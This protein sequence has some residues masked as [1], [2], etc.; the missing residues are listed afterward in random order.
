MPAAARRRRV[1]PSAHRSSGAGT[2]PSRHG[3]FRRRA[4]SCVHAGPNEPRP[5]VLLEQHDRDVLVIRR[6]SS[7]ALRVLCRTTG[8]SGVRAAH[9]IPTGLSPSPIGR[10]EEAQHSDDLG[11]DEDGHADHAIGRRP[12]AAAAGGTDPRPR[13]ADR[14]K[15]QLTHGPTTSPSPGAIHSTTVAARS[16][17]ASMPAPSALTTSARRRASRPRRR[18]HPVA[19]RTARRDQRHRPARSD[20]RRCPATAVPNSS[21]SRRNRMARRHRHYENT[22]I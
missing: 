21:T 12:I 19:R 17:A 15:P 7:H 5:R 10:R 4:V 6:C 2:R 18:S 3:S 1:L 8:P 13:P 14:S 9:T 20:V 11:P 16:S 22:G